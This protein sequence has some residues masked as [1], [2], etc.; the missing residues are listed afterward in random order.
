MRKRNRTTAA[1]LAPT[2]DPVLSFLT[3]AE[4]F[5]REVDK[6]AAEMAVG[7]AATQLARA[8]DAAIALALSTPATTLQGLA[9]QIAALAAFTDWRGIGEYSTLYTKKHIEAAA[10]LVASFIE[11]A[12]VTLA[13]MGAAPP[14]VIA[15]YGMTPALADHLSAL[16]SQ[17]TG[18]G[19]DHA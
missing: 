3:H 4:P 2:I 15:E 5:M 9:A 10:D 16:A 7:D 19:V 13:K 17:V 8:H 12:A 1:L 11:S 14:R 6:P 18:K